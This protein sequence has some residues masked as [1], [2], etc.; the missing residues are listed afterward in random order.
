[1]QFIGAILGLL[2]YLNIL[3]NVVVLIASFIFTT[4]IQGW[5]YGCLVLFS[6]LA[7]I[8]SSINIRG[9]HLI[10]VFPGPR[11]WAIISVILIL[12]LG[13]HWFFGSDYLESLESRKGAFLR[14]EAIKNNVSESQL[15][16]FEIK[17]GTPLY[18][19]RRDDVVFCGKLFASSLTVRIYPEAVD[20][21]GVIFREVI[22]PIKRNNNYL[23]GIWDSESERYLIEVISL[24][25]EKAKAEINAKKSTASAANL[26]GGN[27]TTLYPPAIEVSQ[28]G[29]RGYM[30]RLNLPKGKYNIEPKDREV[31]INGIMKSIEEEVT[32]DSEKDDILIITRSRPI[33]ITPL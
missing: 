10:R 15:E 12:L 29:K 5:Q 25:E 13:G 32:I 19:R 4:S 24:I 9:V 20:I 21:G 7:L 6:F 28:D 3:L 17:A 33:K 8:L 30:A 22:F 26:G 23:P 2:L 18:T 11:G 31:S 16:S 1:M 27:K 14:N